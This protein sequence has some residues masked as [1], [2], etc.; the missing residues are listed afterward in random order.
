[1]GVFADLFVI[2]FMSP[3]VIWRRMLMFARGGRTASKEGRLAVTEKVD[4]AARSAASLARGGS[5]RSVVRNYRDKVQANAR[6]L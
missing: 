1:M 5:W 4:L 2:A 6:R 3:V